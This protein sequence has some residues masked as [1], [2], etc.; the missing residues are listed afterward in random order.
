M[1]A[2]PDHDVV[3]SRGERGC[4]GGQGAG[5]ALAAHFDAGF[6]SCSLHG[7]TQRRRDDLG[8]FVAHVF[9]EL[10]HQASAASADRLGE[11]FFESRLG[12]GQ[13]PV[14]AAQLGID[15]GAA[16]GEGVSFLTQGRPLHRGHAHA[17]K[18]RRLREVQT[19][20][21]EGAGPEDRG[22]GAEGHG[23]MVRRTSG[24][25]KR[26]SRGSAGTMVLGPCFGGRM[27]A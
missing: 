17:V 21:R 3:A 12:K 4:Q 16:H 24:D 7:S 20:R 23:W 8:D 27:T 26:L 11:R 14:G 2:S 15:S 10:E 9:V 13:E 19:D 6:G 25:G 18:H 5:R 1:H 22:F